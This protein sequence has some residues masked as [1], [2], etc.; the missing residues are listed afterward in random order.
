MISRTRRRRQVH[1]TFDEQVLFQSS[2]NISR[3][4]EDFIRQECL[5]KEGTYDVFEVCNMII[6][7]QCIMNTCRSVTWR[8]KIRKIF[9]FFWAGILK[10]WKH[11][12]V[13]CKIAPSP[14]SFNNAIL[15]RKSHSLVVFAHPTNLYERKCRSAWITQKE[16]YKKSEKYCWNPSKYSF[17]LFP[18]KSHF[19][20]PI[21]CKVLFSESLFFVDLLVLCTYLGNVTLQN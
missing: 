13:R 21:V 10:S 3:W 5:F 4:Y 12:C 17:S 7:V 19:K 18:A 1:L 9:Q 6:Q 8:K 14:S 15:W 11:S 2:M 16:V 20:I